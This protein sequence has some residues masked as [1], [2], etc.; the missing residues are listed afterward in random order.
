[1]NFQNLESFL[2]LAEEGSVTRA[3]ER[4]HVSQQALSGL[5]ARL[6]KKLE[7]PSFPAFRSGADLRWDL[8]AAC[9]DSDS[10]YSAPDDCRHAGHPGEP[11]RRASHRCF[12]YARTVHPTPAASDVQPTL[13]P[14]RADHFRGQHDRSGK[15]S[16]QRSDRC[17]DRLCSLYAGLRRICAADA[18]KMYLVGQRELLHQTFGAQTQQVCRA[19][20]ATRNLR[21]FAKFPFVL[22]KR[23]TGSAPL[24][25]ACFPATASSRIFV[26]KR[27]TFKRPSASRLKAWALPS[28]P[29]SISIAPIPSPALPL[30]LSARRLRFSPFPIKILPIPSPSAITVSAISAKSPAILSI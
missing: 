15:R 22:L 20:E 8:P 3:A 18:G 10:R 13:S 2:V 12:A 6:E 16:F 14:G 17:S 29:N 24:P 21:L 27:R 7:V 30:V 5:L 1:M 28:A 19:Y 25:T 11:A 26:W 23:A 4:L 9:R